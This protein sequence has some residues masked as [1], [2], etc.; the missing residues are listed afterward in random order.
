MPAPQ[1]NQLSRVWMEFRPGDTAMRLAGINRPE[2][3]V[4]PAKERRE[5]HE[6]A[7]R[8]AAR[9]HALLTPSVSVGSEL[10]LYSPPWPGAFNSFCKGA[11]GSSRSD[12]QANEAAEMVVLSRLSICGRHLTPQAMLTSQRRRR[13]AHG[14]KDRIRV[15]GLRW[16]NERMVS[17]SGKPAWIEFRG[18]KGP[19]QHEGL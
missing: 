14:P 19:L 5:W 1:S 18:V 12:S 13:S 7:M 17:C 8:D 11:M 3:D 4:N 15:R 9:T 2:K 16:S 6:G 10:L